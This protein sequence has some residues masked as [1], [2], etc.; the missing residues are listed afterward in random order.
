MSARDDDVALDDDARELLAAMREETAMPPDLHDRVWARLEEAVS[1][2]VVI[3]ASPWRRV[4]IVGVAAAAA[5]LLVAGL[6]DRQAATATK[7]ETARD[8]AAY[9][10][11]GALEP[12]EAT[13]GERS[14]SGA[15]RDQAI[16]PQPSATP[17]ATNAG[18]VGGDA[19]G[20]TN[21]RATNERATNE[22]AAREHDEAS[23]AATPAR[24]TKPRAAREPGGDATPASTLA[25]E[26][27]AIEKIRAA[28]LADA[29]DR[30]LDH[31]RAHA[32]RFPDGALVQER[33]ALR[34]VAL[35]ATGDGGAKAKADAF[36]A[37]HPQSPLVS[38]VRAA[39]ADLAAAEDE[40]P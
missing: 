18:S 32:R 30:A 1:P 4:A 36:I 29:P 2:A 9:G 14:D 28:L 20:V 34:A 5:I 31:V 24:A 38:K 26:I 39:C 16:A 33:E 3:P 8:Q 37:A 21:E 11:E 22:H 17:G 19:P 35:C 7:G 27:A 6:W 40:S 12:A 10:R 13:A 15:P 25:Q 23:T